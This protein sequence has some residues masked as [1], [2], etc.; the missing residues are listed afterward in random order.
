[1]FLIQ[2]VREPEY[3]ERLSQRIYFPVNAVSTGEYTVFFGL[4]AF[5]SRELLELD[6]HAMP[7]DELRHYHDICQRNFQS[8]IRSHELIAVPTLENT[9]ALVIAVSASCQAAQTAF[10]ARG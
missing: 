5:A 6:H 7:E 4:L 10:F 3:L 9:L 2:P 1:M 8:G